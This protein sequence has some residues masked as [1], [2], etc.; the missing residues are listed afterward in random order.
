MNVPS[1]MAKVGELRS[2]EDKLLSHVR[3]LEALNITGDE[4]GV[5]LPRIILS[6]LPGHI[7]LEWARDSEDKG[8]D[9]N[10]L[11]DFLKKEMQRRERC[12]VFSP[13]K[14]PMEEREKK[15]ISCKTKCCC[16]AVIIQR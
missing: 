15:M 3:S 1:K 4:Y 8:G 6:R 11:L 14:K 5:F 10:F 7:R 12:N 13:S 9:L 2:F 16:F